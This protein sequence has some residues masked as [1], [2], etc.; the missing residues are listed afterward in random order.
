M[1][2]QDTMTHIAVNVESRWVAVKFDIRYGKC[3]LKDFSLTPAFHFRFG[4]L[5]PFQFLL[6]QNFFIPAGVAALVPVAEC[7][8]IYPPVPI[9]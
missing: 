9:C 3:I 1:P 7:R 4:L 6:A 2:L 8:R 5:L